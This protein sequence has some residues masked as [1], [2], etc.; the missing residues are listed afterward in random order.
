MTEEN[1]VLVGKVLHYFGNI[2]VAALSISGELK[3]GDKISV[4]RP[5]G[6]KVLEQTV[7]SMQINKAEVKEAKAGED[8]AIKMEGKVHEGNLVYKA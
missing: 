5:D 7:S 6:E 3:V 2:G 4:E 1:K 8:V